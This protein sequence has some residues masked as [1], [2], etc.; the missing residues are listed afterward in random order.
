MAQNLNSVLVQLSAANMKLTNNTT[1]IILILLI[2]KL[3]IFFLQCMF[4]S[5]I[6]YLMLNADENSG[7]LP[8]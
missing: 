2:F 1:R 4:F 3:R 7:P 6:N 5:Y 8:Y